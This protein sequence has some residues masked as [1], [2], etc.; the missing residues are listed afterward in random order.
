MITQAEIFLPDRWN[1]DYWTQ[2][3]NGIDCNGNVGMGN[4]CYCESQGYICTCNP[5]SPATNKK[6]QCYDHYGYDCDGNIIDG[7]TN[8]CR[9]SDSPFWL[10]N[11]QRA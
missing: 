4:Y 9:N 3:E 7:E 5:E 1:A 2:L 10:L 8:W 6:L 11:N